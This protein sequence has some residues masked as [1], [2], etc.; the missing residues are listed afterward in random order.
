MQTNVSILTLKV[1]AF[2]FQRQLDGVLS[3]LGDLVG[4]ELNYLLGRVTAWLGK[5]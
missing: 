2:F 5:A 4:L 1:P 3:V